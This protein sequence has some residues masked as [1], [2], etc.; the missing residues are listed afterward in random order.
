MTV[1][2]SAAAARA[3]LALLLGMTLLAALTG[4]AASGAPSGAAPDGAPLHI[5]DPAQV[6]RA[7][8]DLPPA[9]VG[10]FT[11]ATLR[12]D[13]AEATAQYRSGAAV[14]ELTV[15]RYADAADAAAAVDA[16]RR[17]TADAAAIAGPAGMAAW[18]PRAAC[19]H[20]AETAFCATQLAPPDD[21]A[22]LQAFLAALP[23]R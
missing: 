17:A 7:A 11:R 12:G 9:Q 5:P 16:W 14:I 21:A 15:R 13:A 1:R 2:R 3:A 20:A 22:P 10:A 23:W 4:C 19:W 18:T 8:V 6:R